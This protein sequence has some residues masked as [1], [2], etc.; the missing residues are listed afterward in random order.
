[1]VLR[2]V[3]MFASVCISPIAAFFGGVI[4]QE[5]VKFTGKYSPLK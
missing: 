1:M 5:I 2:N 4:A 3:A